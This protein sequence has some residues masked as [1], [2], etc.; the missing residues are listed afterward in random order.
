MQ[1]IE[2]IALLTV[3]LATITATLQYYCIVHNTCNDDKL[4]IFINLQYLQ[5]WNIYKLGIFTNLQYLQ[6]WNIYKLAQQYQ[7]CNINI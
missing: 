6:T 3:F 5:T 7:S 1:H 2:A 4:V